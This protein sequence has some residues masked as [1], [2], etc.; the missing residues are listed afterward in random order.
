MVNVLRF[1]LQCLIVLLLV[2]SVVGVFASETGAPEKVALAAF[3]AALIYAASFVRRL[4]AS[5]SS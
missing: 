1:A 3:M 4:G 2:I 5:P